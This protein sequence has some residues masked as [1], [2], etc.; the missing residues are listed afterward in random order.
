MKPRHRP[1]PRLAAFA[2]FSFG[3][4]TA[5]AAETPAIAPPALARVPA[6]APTAS[7]TADL[8]E[9]V[10]RIQAKLDQGKNTAADLA[11]ELS[12]FDAL[13]AKYREQKTGDVAQI[14]YAQA[15]LYVEVFH[16][17]D[18]ALLLLRRLKTD[19]P[20]TE[21]AVSAD[22]MIESFEAE[23]K[24]A[25]I[26]AALIGQPAPELHFKWSNR[27]GLKTLSAL[28]GKVVV[29]DFWA[30]WCGPCVASF[31]D[32]RELTAHYQKSD[33]A[34]LGVTSIQGV[35]MGLVPPAIDTKNDPA[36]ELALMADYLKA[37][38]I[39]WSV[40][41]SAEEVFNPDYGVGSI[42]YLAIIA[43]DGTVR[44]TGLDPRIPAEEKYA[45]IDAILKEFS[46]KLP[47]ESSP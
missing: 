46:R 9:L 10:G 6:K 28:K 21:P 36:K 12:A 17:N 7:P 35:V 3:L 32:V 44:H 27:D 38:E 11:N 29:L 2:L 42:P 20:S 37:K 41:V 18:K 30:T 26:Q 43:P 24:N 16:E 5:I 1:L 47:G 22:R 34:V 25:K 4:F 13:L 40:A 15:L 23:I 33:V 39:T 45:K 8:Q 31:P 19:F 14:L